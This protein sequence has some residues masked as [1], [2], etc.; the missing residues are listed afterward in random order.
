MSRFCRR[1]QQLSWITLC[2]I[3]GTSIGW[4][5]IA[6]ANDSKRTDSILN[7]RKLWFEEIEEVSGIP[8]HILAAIDQYDRTMEAVKRKG[9]TSAASSKTPR[10]F[11]IHFSEEEWT[12]VSNPNVEDRHP[13]TIGFFGG[14]GMDG[15]ADGVADRNDDRDTLSVLVSYMLKYGTTEEAIDAALMDRYQLERSVERI[16]Q[17]SKIYA[18]FHS[19]DLH[20]K[21]F[22][23]PVLSHYSYRS[24]WGASRGWGGRRIHEGTDIFAGYGVPV[25]STCYGVIEVMGWNPYGGWRVGVRDL[26]NVYH[27]YAHLSGFNKKFHK[28]DVVSPGQVLGWVGS[29]GYGKPGTQGKFPP[30]LHFGLYRDGGK[31]DWSY[32]PFPSLK[33]WEREDRRRSK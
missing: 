4:N 30:H 9:K 24:T 3:I 8:W 17:F 31:T 14:V 6:Q 12:G 5:D 18:T 32:D 25:R 33:R 27:Y 26:N 19:L 21:A 16:R 1:L 22:P 28:G 15:S 20:Q 10:L 29:S 11:A 23:L 7:E 2:V 13:V